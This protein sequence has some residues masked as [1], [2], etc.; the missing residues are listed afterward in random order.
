MEMER[1]RTLQNGTI[2]EI[3]SQN[4]WDDMEWD[5]VREM[6]AEEIISQQEINSIHINNEDAVQREVEEPACERW[7]HFYE[8]HERNFFKDRNWLESEFPELFDSSNSTS[9]L[10]VGCG[11]GNTL[12]PISRKRGYLLRTQKEYP[13]FHLFGSDFSPKAVDLCLNHSDYNATT[14]TFFIHDL[15]KDEEFINPKTNLP[16]P[17]NS[18]DVIVAIFVL[19]ALNP[20]RLPFVFRKLYNLLR[21]GGSLLF[22]DYAKYD[23]TQLRFKSNRLIRKDLYIRGDGTAVHF[24]SEDE[25]R[26]LG[27]DFTI[28][29]LKI[30]RRLLVNRHRKLQMYRIWMQCKLVK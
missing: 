24:F 9:I 16:I 23:M 3:F 6:E 26:E 5:E 7:N 14:M 13:L 22:R 28:D 15:S 18:Q 29:Y 19:S 2:E 27:K 20:E 10:E 12:F 30:D 21:K 8:N 11:A 4:S 17:P 1:K 25:M